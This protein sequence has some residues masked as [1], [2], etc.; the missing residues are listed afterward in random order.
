MDSRRDYPETYLILVP[1]EAG[2]IKQEHH[3]QEIKAIYESPDFPQ[4]SEKKESKTGTGNIHN[5]SLSPTGQ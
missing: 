2:F 4:K 3:Y 1:L 5:S